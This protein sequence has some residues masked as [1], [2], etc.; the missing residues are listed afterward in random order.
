MFETVIKEDLLLLN[1]KPKRATADIAHEFKDLLTK[2]IEDQDIRKIVVDFSQVIFIDS[3]FLGA[4]VSCTKKIRLKGGDLRIS[5][6]NQTITPIF[7]L[8]HLNDVFK[9][10]DDASQ[11]EA[12]FSEA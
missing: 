7:N 9:I 8:M 2:L 10:F 1:I 11:A 6:L 4:M 3:F 12:S 5:G